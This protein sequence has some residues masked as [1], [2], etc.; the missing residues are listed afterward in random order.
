MKRIIV[1]LLLCL[2]LLCACTSPTEPPAQTKEDTSTTTRTLASADAFLVEEINDNGNVRYRYT[3]Y[4]LDGK[5]I[6]SA[7][8]AEAPKVSQVSDTLIGIRFSDDEHNWARYY[9]LESGRASES[10]MNA[11]W[12]DGELVAYNTY[13]NGHI[14]VVRSIFDEAGY[15]FETPVESDSWRICVLAAELSEDGKTLTA[16]YVEGDGSNSEARLRT[17]KLPLEAED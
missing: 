4:G 13:D 14:M 12:S 17:V 7:L 11:F 2:I 1:P 10:F 15:H 3:V 16:E 6:E 8:C 9:D 5:E